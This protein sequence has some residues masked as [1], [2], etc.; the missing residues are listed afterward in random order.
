[1]HYLVDGRVPA[2]IGNRYE[3]TYP[4][5]SF[6]CSDGS[7]VIGAANDKLWKKL[8]ELMNQSE[9]AELPE[10]IHV[11]N[12]VEHHVEL[13]KIVENWT[14][15]HTAT[16]IVDTCLAAGVPAAPIYDIPQV[17]ADPHIAG[18]REM[19]VEQIHPIAGKLKLTGS[20]IKLSGTP[21]DIRT[22][23]PSLGQDNVEVFKEF[24]GLTDQQLAV[25]KSEGAI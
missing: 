20:H 17:V 22:P 7:C 19:F 10:Y 5:D 8:A 11:S 16:D 25:L 2:R 18:D 12:R 23:A 15:T 13:K 6:E 24:L 21:A 1:M 4:Y 3:S 9:I 14:R